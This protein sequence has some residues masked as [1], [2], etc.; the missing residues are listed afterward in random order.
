MSKEAE[1]DGTDES[2]KPNETTVREA[3]PKLKETPTKHVER[4]GDGKS[5][6]RLDEEGTDSDSGR[7]FRNAQARS[8]RRAVQ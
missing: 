6:T 3:L 2:L 7:L 5:E 1:S 4:C 8:C